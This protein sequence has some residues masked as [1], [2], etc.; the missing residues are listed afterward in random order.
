M[1]QEEEKK[2]N[3]NFHHAMFTTLALCD[4]T[5][6]K[7]FSDS[8]VVRQPYIANICVVFIV[9]HKP[10]FRLVNNQWRRQKKHWGAKMT[11]YYR[12]VARVPLRLGA[13]YFCVS[14]IKA[15][16]F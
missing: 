8:F 5:L 3:K 2:T 12:V 15:L 7:T 4:V 6:I 1:Q 14:P 16:R 9:S 10:V 13:K 11:S